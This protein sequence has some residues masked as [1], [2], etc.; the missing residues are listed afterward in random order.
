MSILNVGESLRLH[1]IDLTPASCLLRLFILR[2]INPATALPTNA[3]GP[4]PNKHPAATALPA[5]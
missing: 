4:H 3:Q 1:Y 5:F 2:S